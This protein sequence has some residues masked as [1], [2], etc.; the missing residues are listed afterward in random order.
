MATSINVPALNHTIRADI[1]AINEII[2]ALAKND[3]SVLTD[4]EPGTKRIVE[5]PSGWEFQQYNGTSWITLSTFNINAQK[6]DGFEASA[7]V[8]KNTIPVRDND[9]ALPGDITGNAKTADKL[10]DTLAINAGGTGATSVEQARTNLGVAPISHASSGTDYGIGTERQYGHNQTHDAP[11]AALTAASGHAFSPAGAA[12]MQEL[13]EGQLG[14]LA[15]VVSGNAASQAVKDAAQDAAIA[16]AKSSAQTASENV[17]VLDTTLR[18]LIAEELAKYLPLAGGTLRGTIGFELYGEILASFVPFIH[19][20]SRKV[21]GLYPQS[22]AEIHLGSL[23]EGEILNVVACKRLAGPWARAIF[24]ANEYNPDVVLQ[25]G[26]DEAS[27]AGYIRFSSGL[28]FQWGRHGNVAAAPSVTTI[29]LHQ[30]YKNGNYYV[31]CN[32]SYAWVSG[33]RP[34][35]T[36]GIIGLPE[37]THF[38][39]SGEA[40]PLTAIW[41]TLGVGA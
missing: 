15:G 38:N 10:N 13:L 36:I 1:P 37:T 23:E 8:V 31:N 17:T 32:Q 35:Y 26:Y 21:F 7:T 6:V 27:G 9:G 22:G 11:D 30:P 12:A 24:G 25:H 40:G 28:L 2:K 29:P 34:N 4:L 39:V 3:P 16:E 41:F 19:E 18:Q 14:G 20:E 33:N 5:G